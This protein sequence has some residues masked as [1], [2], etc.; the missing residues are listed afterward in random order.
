MATYMYTSFD[1]AAF[2]RNLITHTLQRELT[3]TAA[4]HEDITFFRI[5]GLLFFLLY[6]LALYYLDL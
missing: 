6:F 2:C 3:L 4:I 5:S 1:G